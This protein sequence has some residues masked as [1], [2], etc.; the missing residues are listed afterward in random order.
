MADPHANFFRV[1]GVI[2]IGDCAKPLIASH[3]VPPM[4]SA[5]RGRRI[6][7]FITF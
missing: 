7:G 3:P 2:V 5:S 6:R 1:E 4:H